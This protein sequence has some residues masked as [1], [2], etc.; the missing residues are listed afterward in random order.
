[1]HTPRGGRM[2]TTT[3]D[4]SG[5]RHGSFRRKT[6]ALT[7]LTAACA[8][9]VLAVPGLAAA[10]LPP[11]QTPQPIWGPNGLVYAT[12]RVGDTVAVGG[13]FDY[14]GPPTG[15]LAVLDADALALVGTPGLA[16]LPIG[17]LLSDGRGG[18]FV[19]SERTFGQG[20]VLRLTPEGAVDTTWSSPTFDGRIFGLA[21]QGTRLFVG[22]EFSNADGQARIALA[23]LDAANGALL[24]WTVTLTG[25]S[26]FG[27]R[28]PAVGALTAAADTLYLGGIFSTVDGAT[29]PGL[30]AIDLST[31]AVTPF[32]DGV[33]AGLYFATRLRV[34]TSRVYVAGGCAVSG[35]EFGVSACAF[36]R[37]TGQRLTWAPALRAGLTVTDIVANDTNAIASLAQAGSAV[38]PGGVAAYAAADGAE[39][40]YRRADREVR[41]IDGAGDRVFAVGNFLTVDGVAALRLVALDATTGTVRPWAHAG[42]GADTIATD[43]TR[44]VV[45]GLIFNSA[46]GVPR[47]YAALLSLSTGRPLPIV[48]EVD[49]R[50]RAMTAIGSTIVVGGD[51]F[52]SATTLAAFSA[53]TGRAMAVALQPDGD[54]E[55]LETDARRLFLGG[56]FTDIGG[57]PVQNLAAIDLA[58]MQV[59]PW[60]PSPDGPVQKLRVSSG[61]LYA[62]GVFRTVPGFARQSVAAFDMETGALLPFNVQSDGWVSDIEFWRDRVIVSGSFGRVD[63]QPRQGLAWVDRISGSV[64]PLTSDIPEFGPGPMAR[65]ADTIVVAGTGFRGLQLRALDASTGRVLPWQLTAT[66]PL[67]GGIFMADGYSDAVLLG[68]IL[69]RVGTESSSSLAVLRPSRAGAPQRISAA[70]IDRTVALGW[71]PAPA[72]AGST[73]VVEAGTSMGGSDIG[74]FDV[75]SARRVTATLPAGTYYAR[76]RSVGP[77]G[78]GAASSEVVL[79]V[80]ST[81]TPPNAPGPLSGRVVDGAVRLAWGAASGNATTYVIEAGAASGLANV[82][83]LPTGALDTSLAAPAPAGTYF[84]RVRAA[85]AFGV[86]APS[87]EVMI[88]VP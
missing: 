28:A 36:D 45:G 87:N 11:D 8:V 20:Q 1:M 62:V 18:W 42:E 55:A 2:T 69:W 4:F 85:N 73:F 67:G 59:L 12:A 72:N 24:P 65:T 81:S 32:G 14:V 30:A 86:S 25:T 41:A 78:Q 68:G 22:G 70:V 26:R 34:T 57:E 39:R 77:G 44:V 48:P 9:A 10:Q 49:I 23:A 83:T 3:R 31:N 80:P 33:A 56:R 54:V 76:V 38:E 19:A 79:T 16:L 47:R 82:G 6:Y 66:G 88:V 71:Q 60:R 51:G 7:R 61:V 53:T 50:V 37:T 75:G 35:Q 21:Q 5:V 17:E 40:W 52:P 84:V 64:L 58:S 74:V 43:G 29:R 46:G 63:G 15:S 13:T 27:G